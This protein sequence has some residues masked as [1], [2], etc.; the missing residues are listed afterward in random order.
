MREPFPVICSNM[1]SVILFGVI[2]QYHHVEIRNMKHIDSFMD[3]R[4]ACIIANS[5]D[6][7]LH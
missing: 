1:S 5:L 2:A 7:R 4:R 3:S 6:L